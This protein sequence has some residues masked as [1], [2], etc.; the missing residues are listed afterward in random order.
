LH[1]SSVAHDGQGLKQKVIRERKTSRTFNKTVRQKLAKGSEARP[2]GFLV[3]PYLEIRLDERGHLR[4]LLSGFA[5]LQFEPASLP[6][7][8]KD[9]RMLEGFTVILFVIHLFSNVASG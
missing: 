5:L 1:C 4:I 6:G 7:K 2:G 3:I 8:T 9:A